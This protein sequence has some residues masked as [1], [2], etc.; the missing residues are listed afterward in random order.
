MRGLGAANT[1]AVRMLESETG[2]WRMA[3]VVDDTMVGEDF[4]IPRT[5][6][7]MIDMKTPVSSWV[8]GE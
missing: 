8:P 3:A 7:V 2:K 4:A 5:A 6:F 1:N